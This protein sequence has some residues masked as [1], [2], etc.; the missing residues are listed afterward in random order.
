MEGLK[1]SFLEPDKTTDIHI[2]A[3]KEYDGAS[4]D[5]K[6]VNYGVLINTATS[7]APYLEKTGLGHLEDSRVAGTQEKIVKYIGVKK[8]QNT[9]ELYTNKF[10][11]RVNLAAAEWKHVA[12]SVKE[13]AL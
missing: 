4:T 13:Y 9:A 7:L 8:A 10:T 12:D 3:V 2:E 1:Y 5:R 6:F 11:G